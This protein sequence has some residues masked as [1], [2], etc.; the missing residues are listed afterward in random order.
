M[1]NSPAGVMCLTQAH[2]G[3]TVSALA[4][5]TL[6]LRANEL[7]VL[8]PLGPVLALSALP[9]FLLAA[10][11]SGEILNATPPKKPVYTED[12]SYLTCIWSAS[13]APRVFLL[14]THFLFQLPK[15]II[16]NFT[17]FHLFVHS[18]IH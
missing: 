3:V 12:E 15:K 18:F 9:F 7:C 4:L 16:T 11:R 8:H 2:S 13:N 14:Q 1:C 10:L 5:F 17:S 6:G